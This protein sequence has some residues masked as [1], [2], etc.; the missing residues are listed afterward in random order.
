[1][2]IFRFTLALVF[3]LIANSLTLMSAQEAQEPEDAMAGEHAD[4]IR[5]WLIR[6]EH[7][8]ADVTSQ[9][10]RDLRPML[11]FVEPARVI[12]FG[13][14]AHQTRELQLLRLRALQSL[15]QAGQVRVLAMEAGYV[16]TLEL[17]RWLTGEV[18]VK[19]DFEVVFPFNGEGRLPELRSALEW[20]HS[21]NETLPPERRVKFYG[22]D[23]P[24]GG[25]ALRPAFDC[26]WK[27]L[28]RI[29][30]ELARRSRQ[31]IDGALRR[32]GDGWPAG[33]KK[34]F[35]AVDANDRLALLDGID[36]LER[37]F[38]TKRGKYSAAGGTEEFER[39]RQAVTIAR[40]TL[41]FMQDPQDGSNPR[42]Q[43]LAANLQW[44]LKH[45][46]RDGKVVI[47]AHNAHVQKQSIE[48]VGAPMKPAESMG[49]ILA[50]QL[51][52]QYLAI[53]TAVN[54]LAGEPSG[55]QTPAKPASVDGILASP[56]VSC[57]F[58]D[59]RHGPR[60]GVVADWLASSHE[61]RFQET[62][63]RVAPREAFDAFLFVE[64]ASPSVQ[65]VESKK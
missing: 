56:G 60:Q 27:Y 38:D 64:Q 23:L 53:G 1:M 19:P 2:T 8:L 39:V 44:V 58:I 51:G 17:N 47:W 32:L 25:G 63:V 4:A 45:T 10:L 62:Y 37:A 43:A 54:R 61:M 41:S 35:E 21:F 55:G 14:T 40:E 3:V 52:A 33:A 9:D 46:A 65:I 34:R 49:Q 16:E 36:E 20:L 24:Y 48:V 59:L 13:E 5:Q 11:K 22:L 30:P 50:G 29:D 28:D 26:I 6:G 15:V 7:P 18:A 12:G 31:S 42:D 57:Y